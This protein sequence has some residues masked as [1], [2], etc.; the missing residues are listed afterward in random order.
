MAENELSSQEQQ[1]LDQLAAEMSAA[2]PEAMSLADICELWKK[3]GKYW[4]IIVKWVRRIP[5]YGE[6]IARLLEMIGRALDAYCN[7]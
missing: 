1:Q 7:K 6:P 5:K 3:Y 2:Q 4:P